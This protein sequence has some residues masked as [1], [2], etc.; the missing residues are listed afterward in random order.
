VTAPRILIVMG[1]S[2]S[3]KSTVAGALSDR[4]GWSLAEGDDFH[5]PENV[6]K[7]HAGTPLTDADRLPWLK[8]IAAWIETRFQSGQSGII[9]CSALKHAYRDLLTRGHPEVLFVYL[10]GS[11][12][13][14]AEHLAGRHGHFMPASLL[15]SQ[16]DT[17]EEPGPDEP[18]L[19][20]DAGQPIEEIVAEIAGKADL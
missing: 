11:P 8:S 12:A 3:G 15:A 14:M 10:K 9:T 4:L 18:V 5:S 19:V 13:V 7:M 16:F 1:V 17:L 2:G 6:A 20:V